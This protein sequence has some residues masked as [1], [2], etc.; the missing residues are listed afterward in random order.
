M[1]LNAK[2]GSSRLDGESETFVATAFSAKDHGADAGELAPTLRAMPRSTSH[3]NGGGQVAVCVFESRF[4]RNGR[5]APDT[6]TPPLK[7][8]SG[9]S[10]R[11]DGA[12][13]LAVSGS[14]RN[15]ICADAIEIDATSLLRALRSDVGEEA[16]AEWRSRIV[17]SFQS[18]EVLQP[19]LHGCGVR[20]AAR[21]AGAWLDDGTLPRAEDLPEGTLRSLWQDGPDGCS[22]QGRE[23]V[24][25]LAR[26]LGKALPELP[27]KGASSVCA[28]RRLT[29]REAERLQ[30]MQDDW[31]LVPYRGKPAADGPRYR[32][33]GNSMAVPVMRW[34]GQRI[35]MVETISG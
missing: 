4:A 29:P 14:P 11:G 12:P 21:E 30:G 7:A 27:P 19:A 26:E 2:G 25:Q 13:L 10:G 20:R 24:Q 23:L 28:V 17:D 22:P 3:A 31:T 15:C 6:V 8:Q 34:I 33:I 16:F 18:P 9:S 1:V 5:G 35:R 32:A